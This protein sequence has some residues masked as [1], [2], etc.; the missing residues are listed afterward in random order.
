MYMAWNIWSVY[1]IQTLQVRFISFI[2][3][4]L[5]V[6]PWVLVKSEL[7][8]TYPFH[9]IYTYRYYVPASQNISL[10]WNKLKRWIDSCIMF[11]AAE[12]GFI[13]FFISLR[14]AL[15]K[16]LGRL[17]VVR[18]GNFYLQYQYAYLYF[19]IRRCPWNSIHYIEQCS[20]YLFYR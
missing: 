20:I 17:D 16:W 4:D 7:Y 5:K 2:P 18:M 12:T 14:G 6:S 3:I 15:V 9:N 13:F 8:T 19:P 1:Q 10:L 11:L